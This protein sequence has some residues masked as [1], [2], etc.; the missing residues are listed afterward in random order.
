VP[1]KAKSEHTELSHSVGNEHRPGIGG[2]FG[3]KTIRQFNFTLDLARQTIQFTPNSYYKLPADFVVGGGVL[4]FT[5]NRQLIV[6]RVVSEK[7]GGSIREGDIVA[8]I[9]GIGAEELAAKPAKIKRLLVDGGK[10]GYNIQIVRGGATQRYAAAKNRMYP[11]N[12]EIRVWAHMPEF[13][14][15]GPRKSALKTRYGLK[16]KKP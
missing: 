9:N 8:S 6:S 3:I 13:F 10:T 12:M 16:N 11:A 14:Q 15:S 5:S 4:S 2:S 1:Y 7:A